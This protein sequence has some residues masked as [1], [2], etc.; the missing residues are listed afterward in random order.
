MDHPQAEPVV[1]V[2]DDEPNNIEI[3][4]KILR[5]DYRVLFSTQ[6]ARVV[7]L[8]EGKRPD[9]I[10]L[11]VVMPEMD[12]YEVCRRLKEHPV[13]REIPVIFVTAM[14]EEQYEAIGF[15][16]GGVDYVTKPVR[17]FLLRARVRAHIELKLKSDLLKKIA[18]LD[19]LTGIPNRRRLDEF[20]RQEWGRGARQGNVPLSAILIDVDHFK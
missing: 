5:P 15:E 4:A 16:A 11:D 1:L 7:E 20:L 8:A 6:P 12:G 14:G 10:L 17:P 3:L 13:T 2:V 19:G 9:L 18:T